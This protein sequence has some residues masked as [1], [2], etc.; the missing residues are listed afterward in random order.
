MSLETTNDLNK[1]TLDGIQDLIQAN[2]DSEKGFREAAEVVDDIH[3]TDLFT[4]M[5]ETRHELATELQSHVQISG[6]Q[7]RKE[8]TFLAALH[9]S[10]LDLRAKLN[11]GD[12][13]VILIEAERGEDHIKHAYED[14]LKKTT[15]SVLNDVLLSQY[16]VVK[17]GHDAIRDLR[18]AFKAK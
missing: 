12:A 10:L 1:E 11:G 6:G 15:G 9:R 14:V 18:D 13:T 16:S 17:K 5:A 3:L 4:R 2:L 7:P 8:G